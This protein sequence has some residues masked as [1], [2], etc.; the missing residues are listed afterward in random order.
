MSGYAVYEVRQRTW[1]RTKDREIAYVVD[2]GMSKNTIDALYREAWK[3]VM[4]QGWLPD[5]WFPAQ[6][7]DV[8]KEGWDRFYA[9]DMQT[10]LPIFYAIPHVVYNIVPVFNQFTVS[11]VQSG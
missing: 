7:Y 1:D 8:I 5:E 3:T 10:P 9:D 2:L 4:T 11:M 6:S